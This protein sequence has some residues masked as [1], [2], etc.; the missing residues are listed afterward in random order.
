MSLF[1]DGVR[2]EDFL[3]DMAFV[4]ELQFLRIFR[5]SGEMMRL[6]V[7]GFLRGLAPIPF[8]SADLPM[9]L[10]DPDW[11]QIWSEERRTLMDAK[12]EF[13]RWETAAEQRIDEWHPDRA[14]RAQRLAADWNADKYGILVR[15]VRDQMRKQGAALGL[16]RD[17]R[18]WPHPERVPTLWC[19]WAYRITRDMLLQ[20]SPRP[21]KRRAGDFVDWCHYQ[22]AAHADEFVTSDARFLEI[23][24]AAPGPKPEFLT[25]E[26]WIQRLS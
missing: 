18:N 13:Q 21:P 3:R 23:A 16:P 2:R 5:S 22:T 11:A 19:S 15:W 17:K 9:A 20:T 1:E 12:T 24:A 7:E 10:D 4:N 14:D 25:L 6:E 8:I 26:S